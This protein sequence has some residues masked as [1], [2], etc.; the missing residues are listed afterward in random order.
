MMKQ[1]KFLKQFKIQK[2]NKLNKFKNPLILFNGHNHCSHINLKNLKMKSF[3][4]NSIKK[5][6]ED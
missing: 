2:K 5:I 4:I 3:K 1:N 6:N